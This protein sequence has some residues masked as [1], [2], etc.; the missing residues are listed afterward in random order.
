MSYRPLRFRV[1]KTTPE[2]EWE[3][4]E[5]VEDGVVVIGAGGHAKVLISALTFGDVNRPEPPPIRIM[6]AA[7]TQ[8]GVVATTVLRPSKATAETRSPPRAGWSAR[9][10]PAS[11]SHCGRR[12]FPPAAPFPATAPSS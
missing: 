10:G 3:V 11:S 1:R 8:Y 12:A 4:L 2:P 6:Y 5:R 7:I 9:A